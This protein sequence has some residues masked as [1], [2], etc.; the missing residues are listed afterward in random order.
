VTSAGQGPPKGARGAVSSARS[1][2]VVGSR[3]REAEGW[4]RRFVAEGARAEEMIRLYQDLGFQVVADPVRVDEFGQLCEACGM[5]AQA[6]FVAIYTR[7]PAHSF[8]EQG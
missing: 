8:E 2:P 5:V 6:A 1:L 3:N 7:R 4:E